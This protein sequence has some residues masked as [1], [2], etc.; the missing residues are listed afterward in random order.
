MGDI[1]PNLPGAEGKGKV[2]TDMHCHQCGKGF[3][4]LI[5]FDENGEHVIECPSC[6]HEHCRNI[7][8]GKITDKRWSTRPNRI[9]VDPRSVWKSGVMQ[10]ETS[11]AANFIRMR[12]LELAKL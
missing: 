7:E 12:W 8:N 10:A 9:I 5:N 2:R 4:A 1:T 3:I 11:N 6:G